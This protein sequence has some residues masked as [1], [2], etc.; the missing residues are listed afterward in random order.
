MNGPFRYTHYD[1]IIAGARVAGASTALLLARSGLRVLVVDPLPRGRDTLSTHALMRGGVLQLHRWGLLGRVREAGTPAVSV[2]TFDYDDETISVPI[3]ERDGV[4][5]LCAPRRTVL[6]PIVA[7]AAEESGAEFVYGWA[8]KALQR[9]DEGRVRGVWVQRPGIAVQLTA[10]L[11]VGADGARSSVARMVEA[12]VERRSEHTTSSIY[13]Y[14]RGLP[15]GEYHWYF[16]AGIDGRPGVGAGVIPTNG[17]DA[18]VFVSLSPEVFHATR[19]RG[20]ESIFTDVVTSID[21]SLGDGLAAETRTSRLRAFPGANGFL[22]RSYGP[23]WALVGDAGYFR[24]PLTAHGMTDAMRDAEILARTIVAGGNLA[25]YQEARDAAA[26][27]LFEVTDAIASLEW[28]NEEVKALHHRLSKEM[29]VGVE[30]IRG[31]GPA[32]TSGSARSA[33]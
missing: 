9:S 22:R 26:D 18:C 21:P 30:V 16:R 24:D 13:A 6:D 10:D 14:H 11:V 27:G 25:A 33:A 2:T 8:V 28:S 1:V 17:G 4:G 5:T 15:D 23:G 31:W 7:E 32:P 19:G 20:L 3:K 12:P 29:N